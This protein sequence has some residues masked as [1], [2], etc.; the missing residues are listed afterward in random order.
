MLARDSLIPGT[1]Q[2][3]KAIAGLGLTMASSA[4]MFYGLT[5][6]KT[7]WAGPLVLGSTALGML[8]FIATV[9]LIRCPQCGMPWIWKAMRTQD[10]QQWI[11]WLNAL[12]RCPDC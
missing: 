8:C 12:R 10:Q 7:P 6:L 2:R 4:S 11:N 5:H 9:A 3:W 1:G